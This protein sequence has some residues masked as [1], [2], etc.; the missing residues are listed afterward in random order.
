MAR[1]AFR[2]S[3][4]NALNSAIS[5]ADESGDDG[6][7][8]L[9]YGLADPM[10]GAGPAWREVSAAGLED[11]AADVDVWVFDIALAVLLVVLI[12]VDGCSAGRESVGADGATL[13]VEGASGPNVGRCAGSS[14]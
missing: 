6:E 7:D 13:V 10:N 2:T 8:W 4:L 12:S 3:F 14:L 1:L 9:W 11:P 5:L